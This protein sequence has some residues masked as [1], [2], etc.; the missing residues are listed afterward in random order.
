MSG[1]HPALTVIRDAL[2][3]TGRPDAMR[4]DVHLTEQARAVLAALLDA[5]HV[6]PHDPVAAT[7]ELARWLADQ[8]NHPRFTEAGGGHEQLLVNE[9][10]IRMA[11]RKATEQP[12]ARVPDLN[13]ARDILLAHVA[14]SG[15]VAR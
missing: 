8:S 13:A 1:D 6:H 9:Q 12:G 2:A 3:V 7:S 14:A 5:G 11:H 15:S 4:V 10:M